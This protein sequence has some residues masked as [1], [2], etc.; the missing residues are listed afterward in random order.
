MKSKEFGCHGKGGGG[1]RD[2]RPSLD[3]Q[4]RLFEFLNVKYAAITAV[5]SSAI[6]RFRF[7]ETSREVH[8]NSNGV[9]QEMCTCRPAYICK[10][11]ACLQTQ[12]W[13]HNLVTTITL[14]VPS[15]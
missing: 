8:T 12:K 9:N 1:A 15:E 5:G 13:A 11:S 3:I 2:A 4:I 14:Q 10:H 6:C 7:T